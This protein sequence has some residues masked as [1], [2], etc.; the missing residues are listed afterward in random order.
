MRLK[1]V[2]RNSFFSVLS[3]FVLIII[4]FFSQRVMNLRM[5]EELVGMNGVFSNIIAILSVSELGIST[6]VVYHLYKALAEKD[7][8]EIAALMNL[9]RRAYY[10]FAAVITALGLMVLP[11]VHYFLKENSFTLGYIRIVFLLWLAR[12][13]LSYLLSYRRSILIADQREYIVSIV[14]L[15]ANVLNYLSVII[16]LELTQ[17]YIL[18]LLIHIFV[19]SALNIWIFGYVNKTYPFL[20]KMSKS[21]LERQTVSKI[22]GDIKNIFVSRFAAKLLLSTD[23]LIISG[24]ISVATVGLYSNYCLITNSVVNVLVALSN[25][26]QPSVG[27][28]FIEGDNEKNYRVLRQLTFLFFLL[29]SF[30]SASLFSLITPFVTDLWL[31]ESYRLNMFITLWLTMNCFIQVLGMPLSMMMGVT[32]LF[33]RERNLSI[34]AAAANLAVSLALVKPFGVAGVLAGTFVSYVIQ[35][36]F[37]IQV[38][39]H[40]YLKMNCRRYAADFLQYCILSVLEVAGVYFITENIYQQGSIAKF[41]LLIMICLILPNLANSLI[42]IKSWRLKSILALIKGIR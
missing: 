20:K 23:N 38:F 27:N 21:P 14:T 22:A 28:M 3:Q 8:H 35:V 37:R 33:Q 25:A 15:T 41:L 18:V 26:I 40:E 10:V 42:Y 1:N 2:F 32:G 6:A 39:F 17:N 16:I 24:F 11:F 34:A 13:V 19:E 4:G 36:L 9:Y 7:E 5:G 29:A 12:T 31:G 30:A